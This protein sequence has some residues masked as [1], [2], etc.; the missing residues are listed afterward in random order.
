MALCERRLALFLAHVHVA[1]LFIGV[2]AF[3][4]SPFG[5]SF[6]ARREKK[7]RLGRSAAFHQSSATDRPLTLAFP[8][9]FEGGLGT[10]ALWFSFP[11]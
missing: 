3:F 9:N 2:G 5:F 6:G 4:S 7:L 11:P 1:L 10:A 8:T